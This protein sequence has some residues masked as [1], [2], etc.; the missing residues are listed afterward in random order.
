[1]ISRCLG[2]VGVQLIQE[3]RVDKREEEGRNGRG[4]GRREREGGRQGEREREREREREKERN[5]SSLH[6]YWRGRHR[7]PSLEP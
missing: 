2:T 1:M 4:R 6:A 5:L 3:D 7:T